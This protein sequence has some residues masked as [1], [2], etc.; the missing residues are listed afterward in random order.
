MLFLETLLKKY[1]PGG[2]EYMPLGEFS[3]ISRGGSF[4]KKNFVEEGFPCIHYGQIYTSYGLSTRQTV[5]YIDGAIASKQ[6]KARPNDIIMAVTSENIEDVCKCVVWLGEGEVAISGHTAI[7]RHNQNAKYLAYYFNSSHFYSQK[8]K[9]AHGT[10]VIEIT[11]D[12]LK[13]VRIPLPP[14][15]VQKQ[16]VDVLD[17]LSDLTDRLNSLLAEEE[18]YRKKQYDYYRINLIEREGNNRRVKIGDL[19]KWQGGKTPSMGMVDYWTDGSIPWISS[20][21]MKKAVLV[22]TEDHITGKALH[23]AG[24]NLLPAGITAIV[25][26]SGIL[27]HTL[28]VVHVPFET[29]INQDIKALIVGDGVDSKY[30]TYVIQ[31]FAED[32]RIKTK[33]SGGTVDSI[34]FQ[35][36]LSYEVPVPN[37]ETQKYIVEQLESLNETFTNLS[38]SIP[39]EVEARKKLYTYYLDK[40]MS[41]A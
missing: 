10:K 6:K 19:G 1:C 26:R 16:I 41:F 23:E 34:D 27:K 30:A 5:S 7:I 11:P 17:K 25:T 24:M 37:I 13:D 3:S 2:V 15:Q 28:P 21:D 29:T 8:V 31:A 12:K 39:F 38:Y 35:K 32:I 33:K 36:F 9:Y 4:Q 14:V 22:D 20:K 18:T 40:I